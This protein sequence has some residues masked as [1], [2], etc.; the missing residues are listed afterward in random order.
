MRKLLI[1]NASMGKH[2]LQES[3]FFFPEDAIMRLVCIKA[4]YLELGLSTAVCHS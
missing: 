2:S 1:E 4:I 3:F